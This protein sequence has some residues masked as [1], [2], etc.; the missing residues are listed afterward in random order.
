MVA[1]VVRP[2]VVNFSYESTVPVSF[3]FHMQPQGKGG[4]KVYIF[5]PGN[6]TKIV[7]MPLYGKN[8]KTSS[9]EPLDRLP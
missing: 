1:S 9:P 7:A 5:G 3:E 2:S 6:I 4:K 8:L